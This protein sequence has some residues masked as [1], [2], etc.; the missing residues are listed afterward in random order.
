LT[1]TSYK[2]LNIGINVGPVSY[3]DII[4]G[5]RGNQILLREMRTTIIKRRTD[6]KRLLAVNLCFV[7]M[8]SWST[9]RTCENT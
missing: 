8:D 4:L 2:Y 1:T 3:M 7:T 6:I 5:N 9:Y